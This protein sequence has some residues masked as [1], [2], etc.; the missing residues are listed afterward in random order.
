MRINKYVALC[1]GL[2]RRA[3][4]S[5]IAEGRV[6][7]NGQLPV[8]G[9]SIDDGDTVT[10]DNIVLTPPAKTTTIILNKPNGYVCSK[11]GQ[12]SK[13]I[14]ELLPANLRTLK[15]VGR[16]DKDSSGL[17]LLTNDGE[18][19]HKLTHPSFAKRK[20]YQVI[21][22]KPMEPLHRQ[23]IQDKGVQL[24]DGLSKFQI[25]RIDGKDETC[26]Q[27][28]MH[29]GRNRQIRRTL[30]ALGY[31]VM[32]LNR[33]EFGPYKLNDLQLAEYITL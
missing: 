28:T 32:R 1:S 18:L 3:A 33:T 6:M 9:Q 17:L 13:T 4:D 7:V 12:G 23:I 16:L 5:A 14:F 19:A 30:A 26:W 20:V 21:I 27:I 2:S 10:L 31:N 29:E 8:T 24:G 25:D 15:S 22:N 11:Q